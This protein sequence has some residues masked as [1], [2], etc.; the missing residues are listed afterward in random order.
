M[1]YRIVV[2]SSKG[3]VGK[4]TTSSLLAYSFAKRGKRVLVVDLDLGSRC[5]DLFFGCENGSLM[6]FGDYYEDRVGADRVLTSVNASENILLCTSS[7]SLRPEN[8]EEIKLTSKLTELATVAKADVVI[9]DTSGLVVPKKLCGFANYGIICATQMPASVRGASSTANLLRENGLENLFLAVTSF[10]YREAKDKTRTGLLD[11]IDESTVR[12]I[13][14]VPFDRVLFLLQEQ[15]K[16]PDETSFAS[17]AY[18]NMAARICGE[19]RKLFY[20]I[21]KMQGRKIL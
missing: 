19:E 14:V 6:N 20:N 17:R 8:V 11:L 12:C 5:L 7:M 16:M 15:G 10:E 3:G 2:T 4:S 21:P 1:Q 13:G 9:C 18:E